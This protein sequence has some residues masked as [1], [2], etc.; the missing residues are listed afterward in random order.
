MTGNKTTASRK[1]DRRDNSNQGV[2]S[3]GYNGD[4]S[5]LEETER[6]W[7]RKVMPEINSK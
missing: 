4:R 1:E 3:D 6:N 2:L 5:T 7:E